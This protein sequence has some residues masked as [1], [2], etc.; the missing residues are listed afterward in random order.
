ML[1]VQRDFHHLTDTLPG[2]G[3]GFIPRPGQQR[4]FDNFRVSL[5]RS[6]EIGNWAFSA[7]HRLWTQLKGLSF[8]RGGTG[9][10]S[11]ENSCDRITGESEPTPPVRPRRASRLLRSTACHLDKGGAG[12]RNMGW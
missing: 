2:L 4:Q 11:G 10:C 1:S 9:E 12:E 3:R 5:I 7:A 6:Q 8:V